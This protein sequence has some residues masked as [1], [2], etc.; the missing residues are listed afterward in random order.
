MHSAIYRGQLAHV[1]L[2]PQP[3]AFTQPMLMLYLDLEELDRLESTWLFGFERRRPLSFRRADYLGR[4]EQP[5]IDE[6]RSEVQRALGAWP[7]GTVR[8]LTQVRSFGYAFNPV[9]F[10]YCFAE[11]DTTLVAIVAEIT[12]TPWGER[13]RYVIEAGAAGASATFAKAFHV[14]PFFG[15]KQDYEW[16]FDVPGEALSV[17][18]TNRELGRQ[19]FRAQLDLERHPFS[20]RSLL[21]SAP[22]LLM[23]WRTVLGIYV[24]AARLWLKGTR[25]HAHPAGAPAKERP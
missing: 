2:G 8:L 25:F 9:S 20:T 1:R 10:Y 3:H 4:P 14:S 15:M 18:M 7:A 22:L 12:N 23:S 5:L 21:G 6:V 13:H 17:A 24:H 19:V 16:R 11:D